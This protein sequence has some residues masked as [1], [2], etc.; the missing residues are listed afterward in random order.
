DIPVDKAGKKPRA[1]SPRGA[2]KQRPGQQETGGN[3]PDSRSSGRRLLSWGLFVTLLMGGLIIALAGA[4]YMLQSRNSQQDALQARL[5]EME[6]RIAA[7]TTGRDE[8][9]V[10]RQPLQDSQQ[11]LTLQTETLATQV[12]A[13]AGRVDL[14]DGLSLPDAAMRLDAMAGRLG[15]LEDQLQIPDNAPGGASV[16]Q[17]DVVLSDV[18]LVS[19]LILAQSGLAT[20]AGMLADNAV[21][22]DLQ[23]W[24]PNLRALESAGLALGD[25][26][27]LAAAAAVRPPS[28]MQLLAAGRDLAVSPPV[29]TSQAG[30]AA[31]TEDSARLDDTDWWSSI[32]SGL[33]AFVRIRDVGG[34]T[35]GDGEAVPSRLQDFR[36]ALSA[37]QLARAVE[38]SRSLDV[39]PQTDQ[40]MD[41][42]R[43]AAA[44]RLH[45]D[46]ALTAVTAQLTASLAS[47]MKGLKDGQASNSNS[48][49]GGTQAAQ[50]EDK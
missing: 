20:L 11:A 33:S 5:V 13:L 35:G 17:S 50:A 21:G 47:S 18:T 38:I 19:D 26:D 31:G 37:G 44:A 42:W 8:D 40:Q 4:L 23:R 32:T 12:A 10:A 45:I 3:S 15:A 46:S 43:D 28:T 14:L 41:Q 30:D 48:G 25:L 29:R 36:M 2:G 27:A 39:G 16:A 24:L 49:P 9:A 1:D 34:E 7:L 22:G 6:A